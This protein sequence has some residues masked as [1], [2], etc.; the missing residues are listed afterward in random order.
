M[1]LMLK[2]QNIPCISLH[3]GTRPTQRKGLLD[4]YQ[5]GDVNILICTDLGSRGINTVRVS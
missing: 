2:E 5:N 3:G 1:R 4:K